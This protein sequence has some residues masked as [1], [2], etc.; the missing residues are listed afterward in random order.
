VLVSPFGLAQRETGSASIE[1]EMHEPP[2]M[3]QGNPTYL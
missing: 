1:D 3:P 2:G